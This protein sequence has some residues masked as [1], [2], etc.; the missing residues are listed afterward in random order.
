MLS[1]GFDG[2]DAQTLS[3]MSREDFTRL[4]SLAVDRMA[5]ARKE[6][7]ILFYEP[8]SENA[9][10]VHQSPARVL[11]VFGGNRSSKTET[12]LAQIIMLACGMWPD[13]YDDWF[14][15]KFRGPV[16][17][18]LI[19]E[20]LTTTLFPI[21]L[22]KLQW[23]TWTGPDRPGGDLGHWGW[24]PRACLI[25]GDWD[26]SWRANLRTLKVL[27]RDPDDRDHVMGQSIIQ[28]MSHSQSP[29]DFASGTFHH[30]LHDEPPPLPIWTESQSRVLDNGGTNYIAMTW[31]DDPAIPVDWIYEDIYEP[32]TRPNPNKNIAI[33]ELNTLNNVHISQA[34]VLEDVRGWDEQKKRVRI[35]GKSLTFANRVHPL[36]TDSQRFFDIDL[37]I[38]C[39][40]LIENDHLVN[41]STGSKNV[42]PYNHVD[43]F[44]PETSWPTVL[45]L[46]PHPRK[47]HMLMWA[48]VD[49]AD[50]I[51]IQAELEVDG[52]PVEVV[53][54]IEQIEE[55][56]EFLRVMQL[57]DPNMGRSPAGVLRGVT[58]QDEFWKAGI[59]FELA[60]DSEVGRKTVNQ[61]LKPDSRTRRP[62]IHVHPRC[63]NVIYQLK[64]FSW[65][66][67]KKALDKDQKQKPKDKHSDY[68]TMLKYLCNSQPTFQLLR[69]GAPV[70]HTRGRR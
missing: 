54:G 30:I 66:D 31:P 15:P 9:A 61:Y 49:P 58:W 21:I 27:C 3:K 63:E 67:Y 34:T 65:A 28:C 64:R 48:V 20:S 38:N 8:A 55:Q 18:R 46:D 12:V 44:I 43:E 7:Q 59:M 6:T 13:K 68:P 70:I 42:V 37:G 47:P 36:F 26:K 45:L 4:A 41:S 52:D 39:D 10:E 56:Y 51:W 40:A 60:D 50:D 57:I 62:R 53:Q 14:R 35:E 11:G 17:C 23:Y 33:F 24:V 1:T 32:A 16:S 29:E 25:D 2:L 5:M 69:M 19:V 22:P